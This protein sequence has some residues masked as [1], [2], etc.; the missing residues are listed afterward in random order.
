ML[1]HRDASTR[2][3]RSGY[4]AGEASAEAVRRGDA[5]ALRS[6]RVCARGVPEI[7]ASRQYCTDRHSPRLIDHR[8][9]RSMELSWGA[10]EAQVTEA[11]SCQISCAKEL[12]PPLAHARSRCRALAPN[13]R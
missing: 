8:S 6:G 1:C 3:V 4:E 12:V 7:E 5:R 13:R 9:E 10:A 2:L 11:A